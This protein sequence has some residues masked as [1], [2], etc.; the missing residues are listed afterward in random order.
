MRTL[1][2]LRHA[3][4][5]WAF[6][7]PDMERPLNKRGRAAAARIGLWMKHQRVQPDWVICS[8]AVRTRETLT[9]VRAYLPIKASSIDVEDRAYLADVEDLLAILADCPQEKKNVLLLGHNPGLEP[10][11]DLFMRR[12]A[13]AFEQGQTHAHGHIGADHLA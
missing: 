8:P 9:R 1:T 11:V 10:A 5:D 6:A 3:K 7:A 4:S 13:A 2:L 12:R